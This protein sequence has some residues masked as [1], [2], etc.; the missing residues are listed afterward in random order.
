MR[1][2]S[3]GRRGLVAVALVGAAALALPAIT[4]AH[5]ERPSYWPDPAPDRSVK[6]AAGGE[7]PEART[8]SS[9]LK[10]KA[11]GTTFVVCKP[12]SLR[13]AKRS[14]KDARKKGFRLRPSQ[15]KQRLSTKK[16]AKLRRINEKLYSKCTSGQ[17]KAAT[18][19]RGKPKL[20][21]IQEAVDRAGNND[22]VVIMPGYYRE[23]PS[24]KQPTDDPRCEDL[25]QLNS[26]GAET[27]S[28]EYQITCPNDQNLVYVQGRELG[29]APPPSPPLD[30]REGI[31]DEGPCLKCNLQIEGSGAKPEDVIIIAAKNGKDRKA[32]T[33]PGDFIKDVV[34]RVDRADGFVAKNFL[35]KGAAEHGLYV[36]ETDGYRIDKMKM[37]WNADYGNLTFTSDHGLYLNCDGFASGDAALYPGSAPETG[38]QADTSFYPDAPRINTVIRK[39]DMRGSALGYSGSMGNSVRITKSDIY[40]NG[41]GISTDSIS[42]SGHPGFPQDS[43]EIDHNR[44]YS[45]NLN[46]YTEDPEV[47]PTVGVPVG[48][49]IMIAGGNSSRVHD[50]WFFDNWRRATMLFPVPDVFVTP[51]GNVNP[52]VA[53]K[54]AG[55]STSCNNRFFDNRTGRA[56]KGFRAPDAG[57]TSSGGGGKKGKELPNGVDFWWAEF[58]TSTDNCWFD[59]VGSD[60]TRKSVTG[61]PPLAPTPGTAEPGFLP[62]DCSN[63]AG[64]GNATK[65]AVL[66][67]CSSWSRGETAGDFPTCDWFTTPP[68]PGS[69]AARREQRQYERMSRR[70]ER[71]DEAERLRERLAEQRGFIDPDRP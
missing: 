12:N 27:P 40:N 16:A 6:P 61:D 31:P 13:S 42:A 2:V 26:S 53:C 62:E 22:R 23:R 10:G 34:L 45:N 67:D 66:I 29:S 7:V 35:V 58:A 47:E 49:G 54:T 50:N 37:F 17:G 55:F 3:R 60:G 64:T 52:G 8:L 21:N 51:E 28:Y 18:E 14:I 20:K 15:D 11:R 32:E 5:R 39:C 38:E 71:S 1:G 44:I 48:V 9:A 43:I 63:S 33:K 70:F 36:E 46:L 68:R 65:L 56:P 41:T 24:R 25:T 30:K 4:S 57:V 19:S 59:N 69:A